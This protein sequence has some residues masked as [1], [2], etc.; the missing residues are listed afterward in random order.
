FPAQGGIQGGFGGHLAA[1]GGAH[2]SA[3]GVHSGIVG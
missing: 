1:F 2:V 3:F